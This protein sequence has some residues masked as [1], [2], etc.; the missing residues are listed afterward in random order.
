MGNDLT[1]PQRPSNHL[2]L[3]HPLETALDANVN[4]GESRRLGC[5]FCLEEDS[6]V[7]TTVRAL[8]LLRSL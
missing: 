4:N 1:P 6:L 7:M 2:E 8:D 3:V 5:H